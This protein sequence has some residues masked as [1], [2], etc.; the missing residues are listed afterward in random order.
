M[1][2]QF[3]TSVCTS[4]DLESHKLNLEALT[5]LFKGSIEDFGVDLLTVKLL[6]KK[7]FNDKCYQYIFRMR[8]DIDSVVKEQLDSMLSQEEAK[9]K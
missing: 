7:D 6:L 3:Y 8:T 2:E 1:I 4:K 5:N 9:I